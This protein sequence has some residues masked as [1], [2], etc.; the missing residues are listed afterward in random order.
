MKYIMLLLSALMGI[1]LSSALPVNDDTF[2]PLANATIVDIKWIVPI[3]ANRTDTVFG[4]IED[5][6]RHLS[7]V[8]PERFA[9]DKNSIYDG[10]TT[11][12]LPDHADISH[13]TRDDSDGMYDAGEYSC[14]VYDPARGRPIKEGIDMLRKVTGQPVLDPNTCSRVSCS[15]NSAILWCNFSDH[16]LTLDGFGRI[17]DGA[18]DLMNSCAFIPDDSNTNDFFFSGNQVFGKEHVNE[19]WTTV[20]QNSC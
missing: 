1:M 10:V 16:P 9:A 4:T 19:W 7:V 2:N 13:S 8:A 14:G 12:P 5:V 6:A 18:K 17:A 20:M 15:W 3:S 11:A